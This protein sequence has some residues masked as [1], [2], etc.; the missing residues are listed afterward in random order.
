MKPHEPYKPKLQ[1]NII[2]DAAAGIF[3]AAVAAMWIFKE[4]FSADTADLCVLTV[5]ALLLIAMNV[6]DRRRKR[7]IFQRAE[8]LRIQREEMEK[9]DFSDSSIFFR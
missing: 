9:D 8:E 3:A 4:K 1:K 5:F 2:G 7:E 6:I